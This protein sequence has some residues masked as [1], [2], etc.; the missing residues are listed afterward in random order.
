MAGPEVGD[1]RKYLGKFGE[2]P[3]NGFWEKVKDKE[4]NLKKKSERFG[5]FGGAKQ[6]ARK[7]ANDDDL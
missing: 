2:D 1:V 7:D 4:K 3:L 6:N 5:V